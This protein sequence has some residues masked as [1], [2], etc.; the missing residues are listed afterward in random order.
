[1]FPYA[2]ASAP[3]PT[4]IPAENI[5]EDWNLNVSPVPMDTL[6]RGTSSVFPPSVDTAAVPP[7]PAV[8]PP[9][10]RS[11]LV[12]ITYILTQPLT[13]VMRFLKNLSQKQLI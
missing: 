1:M 4:I 6:N 7:V 5:D 3:A 8:V 2:T 11:V 12:M 10:I 13:R 9:V